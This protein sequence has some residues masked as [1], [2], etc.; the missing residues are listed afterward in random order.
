VSLL[1]PEDFVAL[2]RLGKTESD[3]ATAIH[4]VFDVS[5]DRLVQAA[6]LVLVARRAGPGADSD[7]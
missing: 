2:Y 3:P 6:N 4:L 1:S 7:Q 5:D